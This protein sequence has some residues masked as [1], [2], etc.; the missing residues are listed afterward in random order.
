[1]PR[2]GWAR[3]KMGCNCVHLDDATLGQAS[4]RVVAAIGAGPL[5]ERHCL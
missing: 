2:T 5:H 3:V 4:E 1:M